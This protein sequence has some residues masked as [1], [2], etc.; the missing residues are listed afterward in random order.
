MSFKEKIA[1]YGWELAYGTVPSDIA[2]EKNILKKLH[3][4]KNPYKSKWF[5]DP[6]ILDATDKYIELLV[7]EFDDSVKR[8]RIARIRIDRITDTITDCKIVLDLKTHLSFPVIYRVEDT[9]YVHPENS[10]SGSSYIYKYDKST[11]M[12]VE[13]GLMLD[14]PITDAIIKKIGNEYY[15]F[16]TRLPE[17]NGDTMHIYRSDTFI[18]GYKECN[19]IK[20]KDCHARMG[21]DFVH[22]NGK[23]YRIAQDC[24]GAYGKG[25]IIESFELNVEKFSGKTVKEIYMSSSSKYEGVHT[26]N[27]YGNLYIVD[28]KKYDYPL[29]HKLVTCIKR[30]IKR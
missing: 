19:T 9:I 24:N 27:T 13:A 11:E 15:M 1:H 12:L 6:F 10:A 30:I 8:G 25:L 2:S 21:G 20:Y 29:I 7:E 16:A 14:E 18:G 5:A 17:P 4:V 23:D 3:E 28:L 22:S 26:Y